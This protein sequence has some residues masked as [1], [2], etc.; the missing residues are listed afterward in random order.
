MMILTEQ[1]FVNFYN[2]M[3]AVMATC[4]LHHTRYLHGLNEDTTMLER[5]LNG[6]DH[7]ARSLAVI[8]ALQLNQRELLKANEDHHQ[9]EDHQEEDHRSP[10]PNLFLHQTV[11][12]AVKDGVE[13]IEVSRALHQLFT[14]VHAANVVYCK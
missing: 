2:E 9:E 8:H 12:T 6:F 11:P 10:S 7:E 14:M 3:K 4:V 1:K 13:A 5:C